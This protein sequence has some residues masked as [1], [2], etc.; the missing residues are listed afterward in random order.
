MGEWDVVSTA[1]NLPR[2]P[3]RIERELGN[4]VIWENWTSLGSP[5]VGKSYNISNTS[6][7]RWEQ[8][9]VDST[10]G[11]MHFYGN[12]SN[13]TMDFWTDDISQPDGSKLKRH[14]QFFNQG[15]DK[16]RQFSQ[17]SKDADKTWFV[18]Y[19]LTRNRKKA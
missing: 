3:T 12:L 11:L 1:D 2:G 15:P 17:G 18:E 10:G 7:K 14:L 6:P 16:V 19:D 8:F 4:C 9:W 5:Y 13:G